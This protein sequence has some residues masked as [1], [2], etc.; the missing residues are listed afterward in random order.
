MVISILSMWVMRLGGAHIL[1]GS[2]QLGAVGVWIGHVHAGLGIPWNDLCIP[3]ERRKVD[4]ET[5]I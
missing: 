4:G 3:V 1:A 2:L 5:I